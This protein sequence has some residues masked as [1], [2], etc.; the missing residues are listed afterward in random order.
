MARDERREPVFDFAE[1]V[2][3]AACR[4]T[5]PELL[6]AFNAMLAGGRKF[7]RRKRLSTSADLAPR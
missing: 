4:C 2:R 5:T 7:Q 3:G 6:Q 1:P